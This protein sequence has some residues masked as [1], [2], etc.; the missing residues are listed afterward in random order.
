MPMPPFNLPISG[1]PLLVG[2]TPSLP[3]I[4]VFGVINGLIV[5]GVNLSHFN[6]L[7]KMAVVARWWAIFPGM[8]FIGHFGGFMAM[9]FLFIYEFFL[10]GAH[11]G[12]QPDAMSEL[13]R[14]FM[15][16]QI[17]LLGLLLS[18]GISFVLNFMM[19]KEHEGERV[20]GHGMLAVCRHV[21]DGYATL[22]AFLEVDVV[23][24]QTLQGAVDREPDVPGRAVLRADRADVTG[25]G[26][27]HPERAAVVDHQAS[28]PDRVRRELPADRRA[29]REERHVHAGERGRR[30]LLHGQLRPPERQ[31]GPRRA[32]RGKHPHARGGKVPFLEHLEHFSAHQA[33]GSGHCHCIRRHDAFLPFTV[34]RPSVRRPAAGRG[35]ACMLQLVDGLALPD[36]QGCRPVQ[37]CRSDRKTGKRRR[38]GDIHPTHGVD[39]IQQT[40]QEGEGPASGTAGSQRLSAVC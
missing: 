14:V 20:L 2:L 38:K 23:G 40:V 5:P 10:R 22:P 24:P 12:I 30:Q 11:G 13:L 18:H 7:L 36:D 35:G 1:A 17:A 32:A 3:L 31:P 37:V 15:P 39:E 9:H 27:V 34:V 28:R 26:V 21:G 33:G 16:V 6:T 4:L 8:F 19:R 25:H 29:G